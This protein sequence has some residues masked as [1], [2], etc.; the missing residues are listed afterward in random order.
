M[1]H[2]VQIGNAVINDD[3]DNQ[4][5]Y[6]YLASH[7]IISDQAAHNINTFCNFSSISNQTTEC[8]EATSEVYK[9]TLFLDVYNIYAPICT[10][11]NL[12]TR[13]KKISVRFK[14]Y[15]YFLSFLIMKQ[16]K[17]MI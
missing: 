7:A 11:H 10:N 15:P 6:D 8:N 5:M 14:F 16:R 9:N 1:L 12:T 2:Y 3:T 4:G 17:I 13:P